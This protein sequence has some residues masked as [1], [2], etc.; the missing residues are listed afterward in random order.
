MISKTLTI[1]VFKVSTQDHIKVVNQWRAFGIPVWKTEQYC[2][3]L[4]PAFGPPYTADPPQ[5]P[6]AQGVN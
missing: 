1:V 4:H 6:T 2:G 5:M 3:I